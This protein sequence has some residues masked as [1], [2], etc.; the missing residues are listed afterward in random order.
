[1]ILLKFMKI[2][3]KKFITLSCH[4]AINYVRGWHIKV[5]N[6]LNELFSNMEDWNLTLQEKEAKSMKVIG[7]IFDNPEFR[8]K[9]KPST[10]A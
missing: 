2:Q 3:V 4:G 7:N 5:C 8:N 6:I 9:R 1:M 10:F